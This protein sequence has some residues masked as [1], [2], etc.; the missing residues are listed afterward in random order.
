MVSPM[1]MSD[2]NELGEILESDR[3]ANYRFL[4]PGTLGRRAVEEGALFPSDWAPHPPPPLPR[5]LGRGGERV[6]LLEI[7]LRIHFQLASRRVGR[8]TRL[9]RRSL[10][11]TP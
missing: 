11:L 1:K 10:H 3:H 8:G 9:T 2:D 6:R 7:W 4:L 5:R